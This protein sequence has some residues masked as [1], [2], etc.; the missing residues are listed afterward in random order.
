MIAGP[1]QHSGK[2]AGSATQQ[3]AEN[4]MLVAHTL[5]AEGHDASEDGTGRGTPIIPIL[6]AGARTGVSTTDE[7]IGIG[8][9]GDP[10]Y[11][12]QA[13]KQHAIAFQTKGSNLDVG[14][15]PGTISSN[16]DRASGSAPMIAF[17][18]KEDGGDAGAVSPPLRAMGHDKS[19]PNAG[20]QV[21][22]AFSADDYKNGTFEES[23]RSRPLTGTADRTRGAPVVAFQ[24]AQTGV[25]EYPEAGTLRADGPGHDPVG[26]RLRIGMAVR[27]LTPR[28]C[29]RLQSWGDDSTLAKAILKLDGNR[30]VDSGESAN[31]ADGPRYKQ[32]GNGV[33]SSVARWIG[34]RVLRFAPKKT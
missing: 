24:E 7:R 23:D 18:C 33:T 28:E 3:D 14:D 25:R 12:L 29:E 1:L 13:T 27:R 9:V 2:A 4:D 31:Q 8:K 5:K 20:G 6:E 32:L 34:I 15:I 17:N 22:V 11:A 26:T 30:W 19:H 10:M 21:A 16:C